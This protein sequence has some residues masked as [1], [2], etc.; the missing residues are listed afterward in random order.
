MTKIL[1]L[2][3][4]NSCRSQMAEALLRDIDPALDVHSAGTSP[5]ARVHPMAVAAMREIGIDIGGRRPKNVTEFL[6]ERFEYVITVC[7]HA[8]ETCP[9][10]SGAVGLRLHMG[11]EDPAEATGSEEE[12]LDVFRHSRDEI[13]EA[14]EAFHRQYIHHT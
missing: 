11:F 6:G 5:A 4:G 1:I 12:I 10:F 7:D 14:F 3:T 9:F 2:C 13:R 8:R